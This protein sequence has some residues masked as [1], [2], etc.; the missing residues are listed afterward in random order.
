MM[1]M[2]TKTTT[3]TTSMT[4]MSIDFRLLPIR[5]AARAIGF[6]GTDL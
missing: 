5:A 2:R 6:R 3:S 4:M 1:K